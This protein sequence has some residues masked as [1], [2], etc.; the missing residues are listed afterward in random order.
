MGVLYDIVSNRM[1]LGAVLLA[2]TVT[3]AHIV[4]YGV[5]ETVRVEEKEEPKPVA[6]ELHVLAQFATRSRCSSKPIT[7]RAV[8]SLPADEIGEAAPRGSAGAGVCA[9]LIREIPKTPPPAKPPV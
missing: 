2:Y 9:S 3:G 8:S 4:D 5:Y 7:L 6:C 1:M